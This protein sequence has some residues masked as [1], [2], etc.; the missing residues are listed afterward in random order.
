[1]FF[2]TSSIFFLNERAK[3]KYG[4]ELCWNASTLFCV[5]KIHSFYAG[6]RHTD[7]R[8]MSRKE[9]A[10]LALGPVHTERQYQPSTVAGFHQDSNGY[11]THSCDAQFMSTIVST[12]GMDNFIDN[13]GTHSSINTSEDYKVLVFTLTV[14]RPNLK[15]ICKVTVPKET[16]FS[17]LSMLQTTTATTKAIFRPHHKCI[18]IMKLAQTSNFLNNPFSDMSGCVTLSLVYNTVTQGVLFVNECG[19]M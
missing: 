2:S 19:G 12:L 13:N 9:R 11:G 14:N 17:E 8:P 15:V 3:V 4:S 6:I 18:F 10:R 7:Y 1:M 5:N 16:K